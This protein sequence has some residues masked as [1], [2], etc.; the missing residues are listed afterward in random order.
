MLR[1]FFEKYFSTLAALTVLSNITK[2]YPALHINDVK[3]YTFVFMSILISF[4]SSTFCK[5]FLLFSWFSFQGIRNEN[6]FETKGQS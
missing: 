1:S 4:R 6:E 2:N 3:N 5:K